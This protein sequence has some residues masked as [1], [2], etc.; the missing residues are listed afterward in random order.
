MGLHDRLKGGSGNGDG[1]GPEEI[2]GQRAEPSVSVQAERTAVDPYAELKTRVHHACIAKLGP[3]LFAAETT[4]D[5]SERVLRAVTEQLALDRTPLTREER[6]Q[7]VREITDDILGYG[8]LEPLLRD[9]SVTEVMVNGSDRIYI[10]RNGKI[11]QAGVTFVDDA[12]LLRIIDKIV[13]QVG[14]RIDEASPMVD[15]RLPDGS[16]VNAIIPPLSLRGPTLTIRK[17]SRDPYTMDDLIN[18]GTLT[19]KAAHFLAACVQGKLN[20]LISGGTGTGKT[21]TLNA[22]SAYVPGD[23]RI[24]TI[25]DAAELQL[26]QEHV[27]TLEARPAN[28]EGQGEVKIREL[29]RNAL[30]MRPDRIIVGE[31]RGPETLDMLQAMNTGHEGSLTTIHA[32]A[33]RDALARLETLVLTAGVDLPLRAIR[34]QVASAFDILVQI[35]R[36]VDGSRRISH[37]TEVLRMESDV[38]T[39]QD[40]FLARPPDEEAASAQITR[41]LSP[42]SCTGLK[43][44]FLEKMAANGVTLPATFFQQ[45]D[46]NFRPSFTAASYGGFK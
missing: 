31:V 1:L 44:H 34:E 20:M 30:R 12:H 6:R 24:V 22:L 27:I 7:L 14:R 26:Q 40:I 13:S 32:N 41:L 36:L 33:P 42:L 28:I 8:P 25:E 19:P 10:E 3:E 5:L 38:I 16:R 29:V 37:V 4:G 23:E 9:D 21:T 11:Q 46:P 17:F 43:P 39:L 45:E 2:L 35:S 15:A 18:F